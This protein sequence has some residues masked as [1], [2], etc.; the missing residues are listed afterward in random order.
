MSLAKQYPK[1]RFI[2]QDLPNVADIIQIPSTLSDRVH[3]EAHDFFTPQLANGADVYLL[4]HILHDWS[5][6]LAI[7]ILQQL[8]KG[9]K[10]GALMIIVDGVLPP[11]GV[12]PIPLERLLTG[13]DLQ[14]WAGL[15]ARERSREDWTSLLKEADTRLE[16]TAIVQPEGSADSVIA[17]TFHAGL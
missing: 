6:V 9:M 1:L 13:M 15:N 14:M 5:D 8:T 12:L 4:R 10:D 2:V 17:V 7:K 3:F 16:I 11:R